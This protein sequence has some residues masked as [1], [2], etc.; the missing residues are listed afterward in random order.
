MVATY[1]ER[2]TWQD[3]RRLVPRK[4]PVAIVP[5]G[6]IEAHGVCALGTDNL[7]PADLATEIAD[8]LHAVICPTIPYGMVKGLAGYP[9][10]V[11]ISG[12]TFTAYV[13]EVLTVLA[14]R[15]FERVVVL[16]GHGGNTGALKDAAYAAHEATAKK[17]VV[18]DWWYLAEEVCR[19]VYGQTGGHA[20]CDENGYILALDPEMVKPEDY[21][22]DLVFRFSP[23][24]A[25]YPY[26]GP[27]ITYKDGEGAPDF[28][29]EKA[30][31]Y[32]RGAIE[33]I[34][35]YLLMVLDRW[36]KIDAVR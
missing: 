11:P 19:E 36:D 15:G 13:T 4:Y 27:V 31:R 30:R 1:L 3:F 6:T 10:S 5:I 7:I 28:D 34:R 12:G 20:G 17:Y 14:K 29:R 21:H 26:P 8:D 24:A 33:K 16:N 23:A 35:A 9:G 32:R 2:L 25:A 18:I 22:D